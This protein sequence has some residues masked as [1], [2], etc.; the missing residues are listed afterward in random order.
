MDTDI[1]ALVT[2]AQ[3]YLDAAYEMDADA[4]PAARSD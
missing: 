3:A 2:I 1:H 4:L